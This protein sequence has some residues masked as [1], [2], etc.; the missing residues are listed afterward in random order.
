[1]IEKSED[2]TINNEVETGLDFVDR[3]IEKKI[4]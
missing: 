2:L 3:N 4:K 1:M